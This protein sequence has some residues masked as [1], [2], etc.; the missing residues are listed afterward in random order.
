MQ[1]SNKC[2]RCGRPL[3]WADTRKRSGRMIRRGMTPE[4]TKELSPCC[5]KCTTIVL[6]EQS[7]VSQVGDPGLH[8]PLTR[9]TRDDTRG[10]SP[11][12]LFSFTRD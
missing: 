3:T 1:I 11:S 10:P 7:P 9:V 8:R 6:R 2:R 12:L 4:K 5:S